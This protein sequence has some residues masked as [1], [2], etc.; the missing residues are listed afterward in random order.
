MDKIPIKGFS[1]YSSSSESLVTPTKSIKFK[2]DTLV[3]AQVKMPI[4]QR[5]P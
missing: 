5:L 1:G 3:F 4:S 2:V